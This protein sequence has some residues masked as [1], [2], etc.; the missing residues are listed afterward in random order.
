MHI[1]DLAIEKELNHAARCAIRGGHSLVDFCKTPDMHLTM[2]SYDGDMSKF[3]SDLISYV[4]DSLP[5]VPSWESVEKP[6]PVI[7]PP[8]PLPQ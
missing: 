8:A 1:K 2:P 5:E 4:G 3:K 6:V 7:I